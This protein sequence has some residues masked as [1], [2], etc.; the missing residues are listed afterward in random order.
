MT[1]AT[2]LTDDSGN[3]RPFYHGSCREIRA[4]SPLR[5]QGVG[6]IYLTADRADAEDYARCACIEDGDVPTVMTAYLR[7]TNPATL[8]GTASQELTT[9]LI[10]G[11][12]A[13]GHDGVVGTNN[14]G[15]VYEYVAFDPDQVEIVAVDVIDLEPAPAP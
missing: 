13:R 9:D 1:Q 7:M 12:K 10:A 14:K 8:A 3:P 6:G 2:H 11:L 5:W 15:E 4:F